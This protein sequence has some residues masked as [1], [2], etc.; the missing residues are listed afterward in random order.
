MLE[1][2]VELKGCPCDCCTNCL[3][4]GSGESLLIKKKKC[5]ITAEDTELDV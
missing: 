5:V 2:G 3:T 4:G 1:E